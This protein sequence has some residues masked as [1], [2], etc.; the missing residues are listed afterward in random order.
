MVSVAPSAVQARLARSM[1]N[2]SAAIEILSSRCMP[3]PERSRTGVVLPNEAP[4]LES[5]G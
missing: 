4:Q 3:L 5:N 2:R 1:E